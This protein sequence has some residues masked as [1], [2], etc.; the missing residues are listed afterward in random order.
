MVT[1]LEAGILPHLMVLGRRGER[2]DKG[3]AKDKIP[4]NPLQLSAAS[5]VFRIHLK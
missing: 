1:E 3:G 2:E 4:G 5:K